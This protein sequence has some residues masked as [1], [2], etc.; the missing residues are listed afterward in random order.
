MST[1]R[2]MNKEDVE[3]IY[4]G[5]VLSHKKNEV[6]PFTVTWMDTEIII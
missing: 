3:H 4:N 1:D 5:I 2:G 6:I